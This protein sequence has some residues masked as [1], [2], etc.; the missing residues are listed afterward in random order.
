MREITQWMAPWPLHPVRVCMFGLICVCT[1]T[2]TYVHHGA[3]WGKLTQTPR[4]LHTILVNIPNVSITFTSSK[5]FVC[6]C[7]YMQ[8]LNWITTQTDKMAQSDRK[9]CFLKLLRTMYQRKTFTYFQGQYIFW[10]QYLSE[11]D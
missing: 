11:S 10:G 9:P 3:C 5:G 1:T 8:V 2:N 4:F 6:V 7:Q